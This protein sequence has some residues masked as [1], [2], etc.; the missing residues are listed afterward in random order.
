MSKIPI[1]TK[2]GHFAHSPTSRINSI[3]NKNNLMIKKHLSPKN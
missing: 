1:N 3:I 2:I